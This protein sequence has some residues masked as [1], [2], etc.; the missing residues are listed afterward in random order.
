MKTEVKFIPYSKLENVQ[1]SS[2]IGSELEIESKETT[3]KIY[4]VDKIKL[5]T[6]YL[7][8]TEKQL[9]QAQ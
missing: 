5:N 8:L 6:F 9:E 2:S 4:F 7:L 1:T 3:I